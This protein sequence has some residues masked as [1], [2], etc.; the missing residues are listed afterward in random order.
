M[1]RKL[2]EVAL[3]LEAI[4]AAAAKEKSIR[5]GHPSTL[6]LWW[7]RRPLAAARAVLFAQLVDDPSTWPELAGDEAA[8]QRERD[9]LFRIIERIVPWENCH[10]Q[11]LI[12]EARREIARSHARFHPEAKGA[13][14]IMAADVTPDAVN[15]YL[16]TE[17]PPVHDPFAG[18][19]TIPLEAQRLGLRAIA[20]DLNPVAVLI[21]KA[22]IEIPPKFAGQ[23]PVNPEAQKSAKMRTWRGAE[24]LAEDV[25][26]YGRWM[27][28]EAFKRIGH[29]Y[30]KVQLPKEHGG[31]EATVIAWL[32]AR[33]V[34]CPNPSCGATMPLAR[35]FV[36]SAKKGK[37]HWTQPVVDRKTKAV[38]FEVRSGVGGDKAKGTVDRRGARCVVCGE[39]VLLEHVRAEGKA[40]RMGAQMTAIVAEGKK[41]RIYLAP[42]AE[43]ER[44]AKSAEPE[45]VPDTNLP[46]EALGFRVQNYGLA[47]HADLFTHR[48]LAILSCLA[49]LI[50]STRDRISMECG[51][52]DYVRSVCVYLALAIG[53]LAD[54]NGSLVMWSPAR[55]QAVHV[56][57][58]QVLPV[59][60]DYAE[61]N[62]FA[63][64]A[65]DYGT[66]MGGM[67]RVLEGLRY[68]CVAGQ[69][70]QANASMIEFSPGLSISTDPP[71]YD[72]VPYADL[73]DYFY[74]WHRHAL[75]LVAPEFVRLLL[76]P[77]AEELIADPF[78]HGSREKASEFF[79]I[80]LR[81]VFRRA[82]DAYSVDSLMS[83]YYA[84]KQTEADDEEDDRTSVASTG[85]ETILGGIIQS[86][87]SI[88]GTWPMSTERVGRMR[89][90][91]SN[92]LASSIVLVCRKRPATATSATRA[93]FLRALKRK[94][95]GDLKLL[96]QGN[97]APVDFA[98]AAIGPGMAVYSSFA[99]VLESDGSVMPVRAAL[100]HI[101][102]VLDEVLSEQEGDFDADT[103][104]ALAW[105]EQHQYEEAEF[106]SA[107]TLARAKNT[108]VAGLVEAGVLRS[109]RGKVRLLKRDELDP[110]WDPATD[111]R[112]TVW[113]VAQHLIRVLGAKGEVAAAGLLART[114]PQGDAARELAYRLY[115]LCERKKWAAEA[116]AYNGLVTAWPE[117]TRLAAEAAGA[118]EGA[119]A[120]AEA[121]RQGELFG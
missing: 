31:G 62:P 27:R 17:L 37:E 43:H 42:N 67:A 64:A 63:E 22:L 18:G 103:R 56:F 10:K 94:L 51:A 72:N 9:R 36:L 93:E 100:Q 77:K 20:S 83:V 81:G 99:K 120:A 55:D 97:I 16:A 14:Q 76:V 115:S 21:N 49:G 112:R 71:Y 46:P 2:I 119:G 121:K 80:G 38:R 45:W 92:A 53:K 60:W 40:G 69:V 7:A 84:F 11:E 25:R 44:V 118:G 34:K 33:T 5:H 114:G 23:P 87:W 29:L 24:G 102:A 47:K 41:G 66:S 98:Q 1:P 113:E 111:A 116:L 85:W 19:G 13:A 78:R 39:G 79:E 70:R 75:E 96:Q 4:N 106:G 35:S 89:D 68:S 28:D 82:C 86:G 73:S 12:D 65:G 52:G 91:D 58:R 108:S 59:V 110:A 101:N 88:H 105:F 74:V 3:P 32:W 48:Q 54:Y 90:N 107:D 104:C 6:H 61:V 95:P 57:G 50:A 26:Y 15:A 109:A 117:L 30:P 8:Q